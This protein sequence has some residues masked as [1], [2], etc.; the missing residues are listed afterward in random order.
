MEF[1][2]VGIAVLSLVLS[3]LH[4]H[5]QEA[6]LGDVV[7]DRA[8]TCD[9]FGCD[10]EC[11]TFI[12]AAAPP[13][14]RLMVCGGSLPSTSLRDNA[15]GSGCHTYDVGATDPAKPDVLSHNDNDEFRHVYRVSGDPACVGTGPP[16]GSGRD[17]APG[18]PDQCGYISEGFTVLALTG[19][20]CSEHGI[21]LC[22]GLF[23]R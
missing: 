11:D 1:A 3:A 21:G 4:G 20:S 12:G 22:T 10:P 23:C 14:T 16:M 15:D 5:H 8:S 2:I 13:S 7:C 17:C 9:L 6:A 19:G 18:G